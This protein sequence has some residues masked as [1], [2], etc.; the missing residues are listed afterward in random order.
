L[1]VLMVL[2][3]CNMSNIQ[4]YWK[5]NRQVNLSTIENSE[6]KQKILLEHD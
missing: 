4:E 2:R 5:K 1:F 3:G 6:L